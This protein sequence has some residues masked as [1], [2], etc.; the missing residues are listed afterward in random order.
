VKFY[1]P[2]DDVK[3]ETIKKEAANTKESIVIEKEMSRKEGVSQ[4]E[5]PKVNPIKI[6]VRKPNNEAI[7]IER[8]VGEAKKLTMITKKRRCIMLK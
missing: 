6:D 2:E 5:K 1:L 4:V 3:V 8:N 7:K